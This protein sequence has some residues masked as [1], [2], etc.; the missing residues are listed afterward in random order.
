M[1]V[2]TFLMT[3][4][5]LEFVVGGNDHVTFSSY[6]AAFAVAVV[7]LGVSPGGCRDGDPS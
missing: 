7:V 5:P 2:L 1:P 4:A 6:L 3:P